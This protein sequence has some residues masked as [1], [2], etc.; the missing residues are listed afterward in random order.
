MTIKFNAGEVLD[1]AMKIEQN[2]MNYYNK[3]AEIFK[4]EPANDMLKK[5]AEWENSH[6]LTFA[7]MKDGLASA[8]TTDVVFDPQG[9]AGLYLNAM[10]DGNVFNVNEDPSKAM[11]GKESLE[12]VLRKALLME[13]DSIIFYLGLR[14]M[15]PPSLGKDKVDDIISEEMSHI[16][17]LNKE[18]VALKR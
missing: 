2:G 16:G 1:M 9:E 5:L 7:A 8:Q 4:N 18:L 15:V 3:A 6:K 11:T 17:Y 13:K 10:A 12:E 14:E